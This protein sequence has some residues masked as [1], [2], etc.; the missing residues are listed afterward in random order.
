MNLE[1]GWTR[2]QEQVLKGDEGKTVFRN[3]RDPCRK[4]GEVGGKTEN[5]LYVCRETS[6]KRYKGKGLN[7]NHSPSN[8]LAEK[9]RGHGHGPSHDHI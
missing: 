1:G 8:N 4:D 7:I 5:Q 6:V 9:A 2:D 3:G